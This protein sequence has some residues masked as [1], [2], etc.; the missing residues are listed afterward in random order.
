MIQFMGRN[1]ISTISLSVFQMMILV[2]QTNIVSLNIFV[3]V[4][5]I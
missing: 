5:T 2:M 4:K 3:V 1:G